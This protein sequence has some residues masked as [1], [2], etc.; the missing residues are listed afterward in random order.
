MLKMPAVSRLPVVAILLLLIIATPLSAAETKALKF[1]SADT[2]ALPEFILFDHDFQPLRNDRLQGRWT[3]FFFG[4]CIRSRGNVGIF[5]PHNCIL[6]CFI[7]KI[8]PSFCLTFGD[9]FLI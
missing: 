9:Y 4:Y 7:L 8:K 1:F 2:Q 5:W 3:L 6:S